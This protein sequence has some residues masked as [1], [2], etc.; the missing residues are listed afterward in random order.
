MTATTTYRYGRYGIPSLAGELERPVE[1]RFV[2]L[3]GRAAA[4]G[5]LRQRV[6]AAWDEEPS[7]EMTRQ[8][9][10]SEAVRS[11]IAGT[12]GSYGE[13]ARRT[14]FSQALSQ[15]AGPRETGPLAQLYKRAWGAQGPI[16]AL[17]REVNRPLPWW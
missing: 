3:P 4:A 6:R 15:I 7:L 12:T 13:A 2:P 9:L 1:R 5:A 17:E 11:G 8:A 10:K 14:G 16:P